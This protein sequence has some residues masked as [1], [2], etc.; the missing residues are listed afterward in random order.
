MENHKSEI[1]VISIIGIVAIVGL[2]MMK[3]HSI[4]SGVFQSN[5]DSPKED[6]TGMAPRLSDSIPVLA[7]GSSQTIP[8]HTLNYGLVFYKGNKRGNHRTLGRTFEQECKLASPEIKTDPELKFFSCLKCPD[9][10]KV[11]Q[12]HVDITSATE[13]PTMT[14]SGT[15][16]DVSWVN[17][18]QKSVTTNRRCDCVESNS[19]CAGGDDSGTCD[20]SLT[21]IYTKSLDK[22]VV[23]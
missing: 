13:D 18:E 5:V 10:K 8:A 20:T 3:T 15:Q 12:K 1:I 9:V 21:G 22:P 19:V 23:S 7:C 17:C 16:G 4:P 11:C 14:S 2:V 6:L